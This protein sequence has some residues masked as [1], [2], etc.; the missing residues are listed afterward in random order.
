MLQRE[1]EPPRTSASVWMPL[2]ALVSAA[3]LTIVSGVAVMTRQPQ[4]REVRLEESTYIRI[5][6]SV[7]VGEIERRI[8]AERA[9][10]QARRALCAAKVRRALDDGDVAAFEDC[11]GVRR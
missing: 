7:T 6:P 3:M 4:R 2:M 10:A 5:E 11:D 9:I 8:E 1:V